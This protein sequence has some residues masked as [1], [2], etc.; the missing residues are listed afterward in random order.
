MVY[1]D[2]HGEFVCILMGLPAAATNLRQGVRYPAA[3]GNNRGYPSRVPSKM[4]HLY[5]HVIGRSVD[6]LQGMWVV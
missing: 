4:A 5:M 1:G 3:C 2:L 6:F